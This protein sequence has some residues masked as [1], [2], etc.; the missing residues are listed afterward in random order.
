MI[1]KESDREYSNSIRKRDQCAACPSVC[2]G[3]VDSAERCCKSCMA[4]FGRR[5]ALLSTDASSSAHFLNSRNSES[6]IAGRRVRKTTRYEAYIL[7]ESAALS[8]LRGC[9]LE[10]CMCGTPFSEK[11]AVRKLAQAMQTAMRDMERADNRLKPTN[12]LWN[13]AQDEC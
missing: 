3:A 1:C 2:Y 10:S 7:L 6:Q 5:S 8:L 12:P 13:A 4:V 9:T 11:E